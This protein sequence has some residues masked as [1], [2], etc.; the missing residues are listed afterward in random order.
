VR[1]VEVGQAMAG[2]E[3]RT[4]TTT[5]AI[6]AGP[7]GAVALMAA[8][9]WPGLLSHRHAGAEDILRVEDVMR[10][11][12]RSVPAQSTVEETAH[13]RRPPAP[14]TLFAVTDPR[15][16]AVGVLDWDDVMAVP[17]LER[18]AR[19]VG[20]LARAAVVER[21]SAVDDVLA[22]PKLAG[23]RAAVVVDTARRPVGLLDLEAARS[24]A[25]DRELG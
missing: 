19:L 8:R 23:V 13:G 7:L 20:Q 2:T 25:A 4:R 17:H 22:R 6:L 15:G 21:G 5:E 16:R 1:T 11:G 24:H 12:L 18:P 9:Y 10:S 14:G 3:R